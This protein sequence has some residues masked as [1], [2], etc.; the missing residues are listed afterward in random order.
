MR[1]LLVDIYIR[2]ADFFN[3]IVLINKIKCNK[4]N[5]VLELNKPM[6]RSK[7][8]CKGINNRIILMPG[9]G[10]DKCTFL[11]TGN[12]NIIYIG[13]MAS[14]IGATFCIEDSNNTIKIGNKSSLCGQ[15]L[16]AACE[17]TCIEIGEDMLAS[18]NIELRTSDS[19]AIYNEN[20]KRI[21]MA[22]NIKI[23]KHVWIGTGVRINKGVTIGEGCVV[24][25]GSVVTR[26]IP[27][28]NVIVAGNPAQI[29]KENI[30]W[31][32]ER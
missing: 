26:K 16:L 31:T 21:N 23:G 1:K 3:K 15:I 5:N 14:A 27:N 10:L 24:G 20:N 22:E 18:S 25:N 28:R 12:D 30:K 6:I 2:Y 7:I 32:R 19:H 29:V 9:G 17:G 11:I 4:K 13:E 8:I